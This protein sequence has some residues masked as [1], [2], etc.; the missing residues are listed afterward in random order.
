MFSV[1]QATEILSALPDPAFVLSRS[2]RYVAIL[3]GADSRYYH[4]GSA[5]IGRRI[6]DVLAPEKAD[7][8]LDHI[9]QALASRQLHIVEY[10]LCR[11]DV[12]GLESEGPDEPLWFEGRIQAL[13]FPLDGEDG[14]L[15]VASNITARHELEQQLRAQSQT[16]ALTGLWNR[17]HFE[18]MAQQERERGLR[19]GHP[20]AALL[21][22]ADHFKRINDTC[23]HKVGDQVLVDLARLARGCTRESDW[24]T[25]WGGEEFTV[26]MPHT[27]LDQAQEVGEKLRRAVA[28][29]EFSLGLRVSISLG[30][31]QWALD[32][33]SADS[34]FSRLDDALYRAK[35]E[36][37]NR[38]VLAEPLAPPE[39][40]GAADHPLA[41]R[42]HY[43]SGHDV[44][45]REHREIF[46]DARRIQAQLARLEV[47]GHWQAGMEDLLAGVDQLLAKT[48]AHF[49]TEERL[50]AKRLWSGLEAHREQHQILLDKGEALR[51]AM[52]TGPSVARAGELIRFLAVEAVANHI[53]HQD[54]TYHPVFALD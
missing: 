30:V 45:D 25:R 26:L 23:G 44:L 4:D 29:H 43:A 9:H 22:D 31:G 33:E 13:N 7:W 49:Q 34:L 50:L 16:D 2:G 42:A 53:L 52:A 11:R 21:F 27:D 40:L 12:K 18:A 47:S 54:R 19:Y 1:E 35:Q 51:Q 28:A 37:R 48:R 15:W 3:G 46:A 10:P 24:V 8:F 14:V 6:Q 36:G 32:Q 38:A 20:V 41:W 39:E 17:R 5:L